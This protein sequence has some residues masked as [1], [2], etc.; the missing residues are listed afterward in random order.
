M[1]WPA[2]GWT[3][4][5]E[6][7]RE[8]LAKEWLL[9][10]VERTPLAE[11]EHLPVDWIVNEAPRLIGDILAE[12][13]EPKSDE[14]DEH[15]PVGGERAE[16]LAAIR[17][18]ADA[19]AGIARDLAA[20][21]ALLIE[22]M[23]RDLP[24]GRREEYPAAVARLA[25]IFGELQAAVSASMV[26]ARTSDAPIDE[27]TGLPNAARLNEWIEFLLAEQRRYGH[28]FG[29]ALIDI[30]GLGRINSAHGEATGDRIVTAI[31]GVIR[32]QVRAGDQTFR[33]AE[34]EFVILAPHTEA[35]GLVP[36]LERVAELIDEAQQPDRPRLA[37]AAGV[38]ACP[39]DGARPST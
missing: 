36:M 1:E 8:R 15:P 9:R 14:S 26:E 22:A 2:Y 28:P 32:G 25:E 38:A 23:H 5:S 33:Y 18:G 19:A 7:A 10:L 16:R 37:I 24:E 12:L 17:G 31:A 29:L 30:D 27:L 4:A 20:L 39:A 11:V 3:G 13:A 35:P 34:D 6:S 21:Q